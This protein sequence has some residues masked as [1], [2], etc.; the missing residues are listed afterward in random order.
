MC[1]HYTVIFSNINFKLSKD[2]LNRITEERV[3]KSNE[4]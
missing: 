1:T 3:N 2:K 4:L